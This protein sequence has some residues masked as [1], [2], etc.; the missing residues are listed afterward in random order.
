MGFLSEREML[1]GWSPQATRL[2]LFLFIILINAAR[3]GYLENNLG[4]HITQK[5]NKRKIIPNI[6]MKFVDDVTLAEG[7]NVKEYVLP[8]LEPN[9]PRPLAYRDRTSMSK[10]QEIC[11]DFTINIFISSPINIFSL[12]ELLYD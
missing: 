9:P 3:Y 6:H 2:G 7:M 10:E 12:Y 4:E 5:K 8:N 1:P 11:L